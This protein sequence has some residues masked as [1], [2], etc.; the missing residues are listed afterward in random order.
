LEGGK[1]E[2]A[3]EEEGLGEYLYLKAQIPV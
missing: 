1:E 2:G 3:E